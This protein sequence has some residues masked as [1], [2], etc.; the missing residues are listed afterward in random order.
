M[1]LLMASASPIRNS[2]ADAEAG[3]AFMA[4]WGAW[5]EA[6]AGAIVDNGAPLGRTL[7]IDAGGVAGARNAVVAYAIVEAASHEAAA[8]I[9]EAHPHV[10]LLPDTWIEVMECLEVPGT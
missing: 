1:A 6:H 9:F 2:E 8:R 7:R 5:A 4:A 3:R 10:R